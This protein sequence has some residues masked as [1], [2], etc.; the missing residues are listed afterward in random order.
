MT[1]SYGLSNNV[2]IFSWGDPASALTLDPLEVTYVP[3]P[4][5]KDP[6]FKTLSVK[7]NA[8]FADEKKLMDLP[9]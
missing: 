2:V 1:L 4:T 3:D 9:K 6:A 8:V 7:D 5:S